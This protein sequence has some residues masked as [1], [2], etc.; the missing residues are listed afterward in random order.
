MKRHKD[1]LSF[2]VCNNI[3]RSRAAISATV[4]SEYFEELST[5]LR[6]V[7]PENIF[8]YDETN[9][10]DDPGSK[11]VLCKRTAK[12]VERIMNSS[13][14]GHSVMFCASATGEVLPIYVVYKAKHLYDSWM[15]GGPPHT[16]YNRS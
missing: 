10:T 16:R 14:T 3:K 5:S 2:R 1:Q 15:D 6:D 8:N 11:K 9:F 7:H 12:Y 4:L 13:K